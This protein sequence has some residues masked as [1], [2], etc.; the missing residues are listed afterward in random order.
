MTQKTLPF[1]IQ[2]S[3]FIFTYKPIR[4][5]GSI[6]S[7]S[8]LMISPTTLHYHY[9]IICFIMSSWSSFYL[10]SMSRYAA[11]LK[12]WIFFP[13]LAVDLSIHRGESQGVIHDSLID[14]DFNLIWFVNFNCPQ[15][16]FYAVFCNTRPWDGKK[17]L[18]SPWIMES[19]SSS[20]INKILLQTPVKG[21]LKPLGSRGT[22]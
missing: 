8:C 3:F 21:L 15:S 14:E 5:C 10:Q 18:T 16:A 4:L 12:L 17:T 20:R 19:L 22:V 2:H 9:K 13:L 1:I 11:L 7:D 6:L